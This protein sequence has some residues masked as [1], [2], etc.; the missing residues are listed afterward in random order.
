MPNPYHFRSVVNGLWRIANDPYPG[1]PRD[2]D[3]LTREQ[4]AIGTPGYAAAQEMLRAV[5]AY[6][7]AR[8]LLRDLYDRPGSLCPPLPLG[9]GWGEGFPIPQEEEPSE[10]DGDPL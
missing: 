1:S 4:R 6:E 10:E 3:A 5:D 2:L 9:E 7:Y 8:H